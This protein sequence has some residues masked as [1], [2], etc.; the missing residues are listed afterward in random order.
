MVM[1]KIAVVASLEREV[2][3][4]TKNCRRIEREHQGRNF[5]FFERKGEDENMVIVC[6][7]IGL[8]AA[9]RAAEAVIALYHPIGLQSWA[10]PELWI[11]PCTSAMF[12]FP[13]Q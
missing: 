12:S 10:L 13:P 6:G 7:G 4:L 5:V 8:E 3:G 11:R 1:P 9:R 2:R